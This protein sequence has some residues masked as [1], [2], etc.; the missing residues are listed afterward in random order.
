MFSPTP[1]NG[2]DLTAAQLEETQDCTSASVEEEALT[3][4][5]NLKVLANFFHVCMSPPNIMSFVPGFNASTVALSIAE[6]ASVNSVNKP[7]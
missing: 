6:I 2:K 5:F 1:K 4:N 7:S 3:N